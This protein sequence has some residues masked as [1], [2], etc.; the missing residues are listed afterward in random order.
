VLF[1]SSTWCMISYIFQS[2]RRL[3]GPTPALRPVLLTP[4]KAITIFSCYEYKN[5]M[6]VPPYNEIAMTIPV[7]AGK[8]I[9][10]PALPMLFGNLFKRFGYYVYSMPVTSLENQI[11][12]RKI[13]GLPKVVEQIDI[14]HSDGKCTTTAYDADGKPYF[15][16]WAPETGKAKH[17]DVASNL[18]SVLDGKLLQ[19]QTCFKA[20]FAVNKKLGVSCLKVFDDSPSGKVLKDL[21]ID[22]KPFQT[23][24]AEHMTACFDL[25][26][27]DFK[28][29]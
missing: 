26:N 16:F 7:M 27:P 29:K 23:R 6:N 28:L 4:G 19:A 18:Y 5:V 10:V 24:Y 15:E 17:F 1:Y 13:W 20:D 9:N 22:D 3:Y 2:K 11:R 8:G 25:P 14:T 12:G 21:E